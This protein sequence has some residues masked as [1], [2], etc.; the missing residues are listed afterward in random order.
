MLGMGVVIVVLTLLLGVFALLSLTV[1]RMEQPIPVT[2]STTQAAATS[3]A[4]GSCGELRLIGVS[5][6]D[7]ALIMAI[8][9]DE[10]QAPLHTLRFQSIRAM[11]HEGGSLQ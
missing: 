7:A 6:R 11:N 9:A 8:V 4:P 1:R 10:L 5:D 2:A 3:T